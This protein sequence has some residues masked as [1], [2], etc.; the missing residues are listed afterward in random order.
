MIKTFFVLWVFIGNPGN[1]T[2]SI[3]TDHYVTLAECQAARAVILSH[4]RSNSA[5]SSDLVKSDKIVCLEA[6]VIE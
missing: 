1:G 2:Q 4:T 3:A 6:T 5:W